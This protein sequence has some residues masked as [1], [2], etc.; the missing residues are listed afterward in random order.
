MAHICGYDGGSNTNPTC[1]KPPTFH[2][3]AGTPE[4]GPSDWA[5]FACDDHLN[6]AQALAWDWHAI[7]PVCGVPSTMW[8]A[9][10]MQGEG[11]CY[12]PEAEAAIHEAAAE[13]DR[14]RANSEA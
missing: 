12:W 1:G 7:S 11:F 4:S 3:F 5:T 13:S 9:K 2:I 10:R 8:Q 6:Q 14:E